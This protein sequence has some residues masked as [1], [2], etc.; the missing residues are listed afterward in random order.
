MLSRPMFAIMRWFRT[1]HGMQKRMNMVGRWKLSMVSVD[2]GLTGFSSNVTT[3]RGP[4]PGPRIEAGRGAAS[5]TPDP[6]RIV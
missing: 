3:S 2:A 1:R 4:W 5:A 6:S